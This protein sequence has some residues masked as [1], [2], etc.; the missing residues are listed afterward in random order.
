MGIRE[1]LR[2]RSRQASQYLNSNSTWKVVAAIVVIAIVGFAINSW[3]D[4]ASLLEHLK[5]I[6]R[7]IGGK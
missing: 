4:I 7:D 2:D 5:V 3:D 6:F 1:W